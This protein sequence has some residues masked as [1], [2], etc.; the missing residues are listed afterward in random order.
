VIF[1]LG[2]GV[3]RDDVEAFAWFAAADASGFDSRD[4]LAVVR[5][6][7]TPG[8]L[9]EATARAAAYVERYSRR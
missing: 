2:E 7:L 6:N 5:A 8:Q 3:L 1:H 9:T 4:A